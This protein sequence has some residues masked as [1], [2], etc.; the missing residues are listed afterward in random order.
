VDHGKVQT[1]AL[2]HGLFKPSASARSCT[3]R[4]ASLTRVQ[5]TRGHGDMD[6]DGRGALPPDSAIQQTPVTTVQV[7][8]QQIRNTASSSVMTFVN[9]ELFLLLVYQRVF[10]NPMCV[11]FGPPCGRRVLRVG[12]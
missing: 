9:L 10:H 2:G 8:I 4:A 12:Y 3:L 5:Q 6:V 7:N 1:V 11:V